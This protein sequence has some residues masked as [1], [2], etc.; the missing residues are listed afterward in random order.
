MGAKVVA[1]GG[2]G[3]STC[4]KSDPIISRP[5]YLVFCFLLRYGKNQAF[6]S[7]LSW[8]CVVSVLSQLFPHLELLEFSASVCLCKTYLENSSGLLILVFLNMCSI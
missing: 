7:S 6:S 1:C 4:T 2:I 5:W 3:A 8:C